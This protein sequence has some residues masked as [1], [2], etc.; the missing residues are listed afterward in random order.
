MPA[1]AHVGSPLSCAS[2]VCTVCAVNHTQQQPRG[3]WN[4]IKAWPGKA[5]MFPSGDPGSFAVPVGPAAPL[6][7]TGNELSS[8]PSEM[9]YCC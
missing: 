6:S 7:W 3:V 5:T 8:A 1:M 2:L 4:A 9:I